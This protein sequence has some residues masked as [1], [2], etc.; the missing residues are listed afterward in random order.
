MKRNWLE[1]AVLGLSVAVVLAVAGVLVADGLGDSQSEPRLRVELT[2]EPMRSGD[3]WLVPAEVLN[4]GNAPATNLLVEATAELEGGTQTS[5]V[6]LDFAPPG[7]TTQVVFAFSGQPQA[8]LGAR[9]VA[10]ELP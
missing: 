3:G 5:Q 4:E 6:R 2:G 8:D 1:W 9:I 7:S 10:F